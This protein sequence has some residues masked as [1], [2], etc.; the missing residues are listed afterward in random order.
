MG[1]VLRLQRIWLAF[2]ATLAMAFGLL[3]QVAPAVAGEPVAINIVVIEASRSGKSLDPRLTA[4]K[5]HKS[6]KVMGF[7]STEVMDELNTK[8]ELGSSVS[9]QML[10]K[11]G[12]ARNLRVKVLAIDLKAKI[13]TLNVSVPEFTFKTD[14][15]H[16]N[17][18]TL[19]VA[20]PR[21]DDK[22]TIFLAVTPKL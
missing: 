15:E 18:G 21:K 22:K 9:L 17:G 12:K 2:A 10:G 6:L 14:T 8:V 19:M 16:K 4:L 1:S 20:I 13:V 3:V 7:K 5:L 11:S